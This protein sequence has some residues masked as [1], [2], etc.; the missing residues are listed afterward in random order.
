MRQKVTRVGRAAK[1][2]IFRS[3][4]FTS[5]PSNHQTLFIEQVQDP[6]LGLNQV[7]DRL[8]VVE[9]YQRPRYVLSHVL[10]LLKLEHMLMENKKDIRITPPRA[11]EARYTVF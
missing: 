6:H 3:A 2:D 4:K 8:I 1:Y 5:R 11:D 10:L 7:N 9:V